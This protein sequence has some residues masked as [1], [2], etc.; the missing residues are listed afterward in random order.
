MVCHIFSL[1]F[2]VVLLRE[3]NSSIAPLIRISNATQHELRRDVR[4]VICSYW[5]SL[6][7]SLFF[8]LLFVLLSLVKI[9]RAPSPFHFI[10]KTIIEAAPFSRFNST[11]YSL[12]PEPMNSPHFF[13]PL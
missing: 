6:I 13:C 12:V 4:A 3:A 5:L 11:L 1:L 10:G 8:S 7:V 9:N 2:I